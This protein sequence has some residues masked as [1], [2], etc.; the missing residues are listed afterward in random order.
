[1]SQRS[2]NPAR[3]EVVHP[4]WVSMSLSVPV[5]DLLIRLMSC[6]AG[7]PSQEVR[8]RNESINGHSS[9]FRESI[10]FLIEFYFEGRC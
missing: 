4:Y 10:E 6:D 5:L 2:S 3:Q 9:E 1:M 8:K 7:H